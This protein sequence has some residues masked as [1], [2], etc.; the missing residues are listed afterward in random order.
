MKMDVGGM[1]E[2]LEEKEK[3]FKI[4]QEGEEGKETRV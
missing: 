4:N 2:S 3:E 1:G